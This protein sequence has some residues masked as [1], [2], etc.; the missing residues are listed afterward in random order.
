MSIVT[1]LC[2]KVKTETPLQFKKLEK[3]MK[4]YTASLVQQGQM[5]LQIF[6]ESPVGHAFDW[7]ED[8]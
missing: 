4:K 3:Q 6:N 7:E 1:L 8:R 2:D 5:P